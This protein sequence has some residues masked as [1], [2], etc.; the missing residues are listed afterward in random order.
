MI[1]SS[2]NDQLSLLNSCWTLWTKCRKRLSK[3]LMEAPRLVATAVGRP[4][5]MEQDREMKAGNL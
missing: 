5:E 2:E 3:R 4:N 1:R